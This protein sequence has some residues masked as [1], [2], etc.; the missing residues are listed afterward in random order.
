MFFIVI[1][2]FCPVIAQNIPHKDHRPER[3][4]YVSQ[5]IKPG[6]IGAEIGVAIG[7]FSYH[8]LL[9][10]NPTKLYLIDLWMYGLQKDI[11][12][13]ESTLQKQESRDNQYEGVCKLFQPYKNVE[14]IRLRSEEA[15]DMFENNYF[16]YVYIDGEHSYEAVSRDLNNYFPKVKVGGYLIGDDY[17]WLG[18][19]PAVKD[20]LEAHKDNCEFVDA[21]VCQY[22]LRRIK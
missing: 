16:D 13:E 21:Q 9:Q 15:F 2:G 18:V 11:E 20:F 7:S 19:E 17:G 14:I 5:F 6:D 12:K 1:T 3:A 4:E 22:V 10:K 8:V